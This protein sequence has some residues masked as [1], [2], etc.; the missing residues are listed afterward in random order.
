MLCEST[1]TLARRNSQRTS[2]LCTNRDEFLDRPT[3]NAQFHSF[4]TFTGT[5][6]QH[7]V[8][9]GRDELAGGS[10][11]GINRTGKVALL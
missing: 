2:I 10:W 4:G 5:D 11:F 9:S 3:Q 7:Q 8:L 6:Q 1:S